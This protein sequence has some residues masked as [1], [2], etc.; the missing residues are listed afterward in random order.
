M[1]VSHYDCKLGQFTIMIQQITA[2]YVS[3]VG[4]GVQGKNDQLAKIWQDLSEEKIKPYDQ[5]T[6]GEG[7]TENQHPCLSRGALKVQ[8]DEKGG[9]QTNYRVTPSSC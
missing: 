1:K 2:D 8:L 6:R 7:H 4:I 5:L 3:I 9:G